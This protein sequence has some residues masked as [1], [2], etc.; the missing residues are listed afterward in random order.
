MVKSN[1]GN[2]RFT[3]KAQL[4]WQYRQMFL[5][6]TAQLAPEVAESLKELCPMYEAVKNIYP[7]TA[8]LSAWIRGDYDIDDPQVADLQRSAFLARA[9]HKNRD[10]IADDQWDPG[11]EERAW[12]KLIDLR[13]AYADFIDRYGLKS[14]WLREGL[15]KVLGD[16]AG[17]PRHSNSLGG[18]YN[19]AWFP[20]HG[21][22]IDLQIEGWNVEENWAEF[23]ERAKLQFEAALSLHRNET[24]E[25]FR[26]CG[27]KKTTKP[28][29]FEPL[30]WLVWWTVK[31]MSKYDIQALIDADNVSTEKFYETKTIDHHFRQ[32]RD[33]GLPVR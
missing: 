8:D 5:S 31:G 33:Y 12:K 24:I 15:F 30:K 9:A 29:S 23:E 2:F 6:Y 13:T 18:A 14:D 4:P 11:A 3:D 19:H 20:I 16:M 7:L 28:L 22:E 1:P 17:N 27:Y 21:K 26:N 32:L 10:I 25:H